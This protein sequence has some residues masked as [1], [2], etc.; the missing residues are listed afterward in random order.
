[1]GIEE[2][3]GKKITNIWLWQQMDVGGLD[4][5]EVFIEL[6]QK[7]ILDIPYSFSQ[8]IWIKTIDKEVISFFDDQTDEKTRL[9]RGNIFYSKFKKIVAPTLFFL[10][11]KFSYSFNHVK[12][13]IKYLKD[14]VITDFLLYPNDDKGVLELKNGCF[15]TETQ[16]SP[17]G[18]G[19]AGL[20]FFES[21]AKL[22]ESK[23]KNYIRLSDRV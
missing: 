21:L 7:I 11:G 3:I 12:H 20:I 4:E 22:E 23:G 10:K 16:I 2:I 15:L 1:M 6:D 14:Q 13:N 5:A 9:G 18:T 8:D 17:H 19:T